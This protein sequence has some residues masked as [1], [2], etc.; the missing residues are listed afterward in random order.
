T[1]DLAGAVAYLLAHEQV[2][3][4]T[5]GVVGFCMGGKFAIVLAAQ[6]G[7]RIGATV[8]F[9]GLPAVSETDFSA[10]TA[11]MLCHFGEHDRTISHEAIEELRE[12][13]ERESAVR[14]DIHLY[15]AGHAFCND[16]NPA[17]YHSDSAR[18]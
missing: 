7:A 16:R 1:R 10:L 15:P 6:Q 14:P 2:T 13:V 4:S 8:P 9:Y 5:V 3:G 18:L 12:R 11:P 17:S